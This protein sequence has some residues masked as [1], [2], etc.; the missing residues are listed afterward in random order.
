MTT[1]IHVLGISGSLR[2]ASWNTGLLHAAGDLLPEGMS[3]EI[4]DL[5]AIPLFNQDHDGLAAPEA[6]K[7][8]RARIRA[9]D[10]LLIATPEYNGSITGVLKNAIDWASRPISD[11]PLSGKPLAIMGAGGVSGTI[12]AQL[13]LRQLSAAINT[14]IINRPQVQ[15]MRSWDK[16]DAEGQLTD[17]QSRQE[18]RALLEALAAWTRRLRGE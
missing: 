11:S 4:A 5:A 15:I 7:H 1:S 9:A 8:F 3:L 14:L 13:A 6:V 2:R 10:A 16:F 18:I 17:E 12:R